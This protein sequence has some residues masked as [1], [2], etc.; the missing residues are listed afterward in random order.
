MKGANGKS[1]LPND[2]TKPFAVDISEQQTDWSVYKRVQVRCKQAAVND[3]VD[4]PGFVDFYRHDKRIHR[5]KNPVTTS[6][7]G[8]NDI[9]DASQFYQGPIYGMSGFPGFVYCPRALSESVQTELAFEAVTK[10][11]EAPHTTNI[12]LLPPK[13][14]E[15][16]N[17]A[18]QTMWH[19]W[20]AERANSDGNSSEPST[21]ATATTSPPTKKRYRSFHKLSWAT[22]GYHY[23]WTKR[24]YHEGAKSTMPES[25]NSIATLFARTALAIE[26]KSSS[27]D[28]EPPQFTPSASI[29]NFYHQKSI[30]GGHR[31]DKEYALDKPVVSISLGL[32][33]IFLLGGKTKDE[34]PVVPILV[35]PGDVMLLA[36]GTRLNIHGMARVLSLSGEQS[37]Q[38]DL[39]PNV[40][41]DRLPKTTQQVSSIACIPCN[42]KTTTASNSKEEEKQNKGQYR[43]PEKDDAHSLQSFLE[44]HRININVRQV[45]K[46]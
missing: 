33:A 21:I 9:D 25:L 14:S 15:V 28:K 38:H 19:L 6:E 26:S 41:N 1:A 36:G 20:K 5:L 43:F 10:Y 4:L 13:T 37:H 7:A 16:E 11:C 45:H 24:A 35:R 46:D 32:P 42:L 23:D 12:E 31:D 17:E 34:T 39:L 27:L 8:F 30:M 29:V 22:T 40:A 3:I 18:H 44:T 2:K